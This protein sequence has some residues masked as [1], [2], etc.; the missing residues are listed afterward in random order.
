MLD[1]DYRVALKKLVKEK[2]IED[3]LISYEWGIRSHREYAELHREEIVRRLQ[4]E[5]SLKD[6]VAFYK[7]ACFKQN[8]E[9]EQTLGKA[10]GYPWFKDSPEIFPEAIEEDGVCV[11]DHVAESLAVE[12]A[13]RIKSYEEKINKVTDNLNMLTKA[14][15]ELISPS[16]IR[17]ELQATI[18]FLLNEQV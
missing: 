12:A 5:T 3:L 2:S 16:Y 17:A 7:D 1:E 9:I 4:E 8:H 13:N 15:L 18:N 14:N 10:L 6:D 11:G